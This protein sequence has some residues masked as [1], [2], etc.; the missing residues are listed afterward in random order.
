ME[1]CVRKIKRSFLGYSPLRLAKNC[2]GKVVCGEIFFHFHFFLFSGTI[3]HRKNF[4]FTSS[5]S[6]RKRRRCAKIRNSWDPKIDRFLID[7]KVENKN[8]K[9]ERLLCGFN[10]P[11]LMIYLFSHELSISLRLFSLKTFKTHKFSF[12]PHHRWLQASTTWG[13]SFSANEWD[14]MCGNMI[15]CSSRTNLHTLSWI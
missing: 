14:L 5:A 3:N 6:P 4:F 8:E 12:P 2:W 9:L 11:H 10:G 13:L 1:I 15:L 7:H